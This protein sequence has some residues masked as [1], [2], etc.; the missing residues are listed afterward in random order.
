MNSSEN[1]SFSCP[2][3]GHVQIKDFKCLLASKPGQCCGVVIASSS[4]HGRSCN[5]LALQPA[6][7]LSDFG[8]IDLF[9]PG[10]LALTRAVRGVA[11]VVQEFALLLA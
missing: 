8:R 1:I 4:E 11:A 9:D 6:P 2:H 7:D 10:V 5:R 3:S